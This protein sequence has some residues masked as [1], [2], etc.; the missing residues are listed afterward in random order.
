VG[1][2]PPRAKVTSV[3][4]QLEPLGDF[5]FPIVEADTCKLFDI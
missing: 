1:A 2:L 5:A 4:V 3:P